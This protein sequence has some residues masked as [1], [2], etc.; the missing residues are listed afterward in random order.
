MNEIIRVEDIFDKLSKAVKLWATKDVDTR[1]QE[2]DDSNTTEY[3]LTD[4]G[5]W[6]LNILA[7]INKMNSFDRFEVI[8]EFVAG[9]GNTIDQYQILKVFLRLVYPAAVLMDATLNK[10]RRA[11]DFLVNRTG[12]KVVYKFKDGTEVCGRVLRPDEFVEAQRDLLH[13][14]NRKVVQA[15]PLVPVDRP[16]KTI[17]SAMVRGCVTRI[18][19][20]NRVI[21]DT[22]A[23]DV[24]LYVIDNPNWYAAKTYTE[25]DEDMVKDIVLSLIKG[26]KDAAANPAAL[27]MDVASTKEEVNSNDGNQS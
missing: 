23:S 5:E 22:D 17:D 9:Q 6:L 2:S 24:D 11:V 25:L 19:G 10:D 13:A 27:R 4:A 12:N 18:S 16:I 15:A 20:K 14:I 3:Y 26:I 7:T 8:N 21:S 1:K